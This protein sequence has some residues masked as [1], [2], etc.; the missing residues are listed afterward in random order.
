MQAGILDDL[1][2]QARYLRLA[3]VPGA[4]PRPALRRLAR[5]VDGRATVVGLGPGLI[6]AC[7]P[8]AQARLPGLRP[9]PAWVGR[10]VHSPSTP[11]ELWL[12][13]RG[14]DRGELFHRARH[15]AGLLGDTAFRLIDAIDAFRHRDGRDLSGYVDGT[16]NPQGDRA[17]E[18]AI[19]GGAGPG[20]DGGSFV[21]VQQWRHDFEA[22]DAM[23][24]RARD[25]ALGRRLADNEEID[26]A[27]ASAH[28]KRT[29]QESFEPPAF[30]WRRSMPWVRD[31]QAGLMFVSFGAT[32]DAF[33]AQWRRMLG[34]DDGVP[35]AVFG[36]SRPITGATFWCP[37]M[38][39]GAL[40]LRALGR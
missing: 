9:M 12:W 3:G 26:S 16:E 24:A 39:G 18:V 5:A 30:S 29:A 33:E 27:P 34:L 23:R 15:L 8:R 37:P 25:L 4:D 6:A 31:D 38:N 21:A 40:D 32:L 19:V 7:G 10:G 11:A 36:L 17:R 1:P 14:E 22:I 35:D 2:P 13:L 20:L 28:V